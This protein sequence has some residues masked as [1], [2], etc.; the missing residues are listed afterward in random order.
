MVGIEGLGDQVGVDELVAGL[1]TDRIEAD[2]E[3]GQRVLA[4]LG[5]Q[6]HHDR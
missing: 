6:C 3:C 4:L 5:E 2:T 1:I